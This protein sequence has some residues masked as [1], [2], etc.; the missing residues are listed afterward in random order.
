MAATENGPMLWNPYSDDRLEYNELAW[1]Q[2]EKSF[3]QTYR[4]KLAN[5]IVL[6][7]DLDLF[8]TLHELDYRRFP[9]RDEFIE[10]Y[11]EELGEYMHNDLC[12]LK[13]DA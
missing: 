4:Q 12:V 13:P 9:S 7:Y 2:N 8:D 3:S 6:E 1:H 5:E 11:F 10:E